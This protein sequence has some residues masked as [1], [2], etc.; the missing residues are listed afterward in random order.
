MLVPGTSKSTVSR[1]AGTVDCTCSYESWYE[2]SKLRSVLPLQLLHPLVLHRL[3]T[4][5]YS[6]PGTKKNEGSTSSAALGHSRAQAVKR[7]RFV[8]LRAWLEN[9]CV[10]SRWSTSGCKSCGGC[11]ICEHNRRCIECR[12]C[13]SNN[14]AIIARLDLLC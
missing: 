8:H 2:A 4:H 9:R 7:N 5:L 13:G 10:S 14:R 6:H 1:R 3:E 12:S 11:S